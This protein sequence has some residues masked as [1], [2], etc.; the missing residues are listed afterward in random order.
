MTKLYRDEEAAWKKLRTFTT[1]VIKNFKQKQ[2][3]REVPEYIED[4]NN[5][6]VK[7]EVQ[8]SS[9]LRKPKVFVDKV[10]EL[11]QSLPEFNNKCVTDELDTLI[12][13]VSIF[14]KSVKFAQMY[15]LVVTQTSHSN[16][17]FWSL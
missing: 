12:A 3:P 15:F 11:A 4:C 6:D 17:E 14:Q 16:V 7:N 13:G 10:F 2:Q 9:V 5:N 1:S 8:E